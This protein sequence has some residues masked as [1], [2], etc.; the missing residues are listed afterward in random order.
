MKAASEILQKFQNQKEITQHEMAKL[1]Q[2]SQATYNNWVNNRTPINPKYYPAIA[3]LGQIDVATL[4]PPNAKVNIINN[5]FPKEG[6]SVN[7]LELYK[8]YTENLE[9]TNRILKNEN[10]K[11]LAILE[12]NKAVFTSFQQRRVQ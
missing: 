7:A 10:E 2:I 8:K 1:L 4:I 11:L 5:T 9:E 12:E 6:I 3:T